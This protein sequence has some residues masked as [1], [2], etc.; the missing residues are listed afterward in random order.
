MS[1]QQFGAVVINTL[2]NV[3]VAIHEQT[4]I[5]IPARDHGKLSMLADAVSYLSAAPQPASPAG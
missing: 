5:E 1:E 2:T 3:I 4:G